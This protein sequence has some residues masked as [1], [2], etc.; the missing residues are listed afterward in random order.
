MIYAVSI[1]KTRSILIKPSYLCISNMPCAYVA[2]GFNYD[3]FLMHYL[4]Y[5]QW[6]VIET[7]H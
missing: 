5:L 3:L 2:S 6:L 7:K 1:G 4:K